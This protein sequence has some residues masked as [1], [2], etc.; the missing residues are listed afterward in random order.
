MAKPTP[1]PPA[2]KIAG[3]DFGTVRIGIAICD[4]E[5]IMA[6]PYEV[7]RRRSERLD[8]ER[9]QELVRSEQIVHFVLGLPLHNSG[10]LS[11]K[12]REAIEFG[13]KLVEATG[14]TIDYVDE[15]FTSREAESYLRQGNLNAKK[16]KEKL[17][18]VAAQ[19]ILATYLERGCVGTTDFLALDD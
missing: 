9:F 1:P 3:I 10:E 11:D 7:Y 12:A 17:D 5:R 13:D 4:P 19:I 8:L 6:F 2:G 14:L 15:R 16:R 18:A